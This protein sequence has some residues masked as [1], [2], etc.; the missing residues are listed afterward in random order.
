ME[1]KLE[2]K[3]LIHKKA[4]ADQLIAAIAQP[5]ERTHGKGEVTGSIPVRG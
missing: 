1:S 2:N 5:V 4:Q 3:T